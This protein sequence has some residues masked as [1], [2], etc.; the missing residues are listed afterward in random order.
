M[1]AKARYGEIGERV[2]GIQDTGAAVQNMRLAALE[3]GVK[4]CLLR[5]FDH[6]AMARQ[7]ELPRHVEPL[8]LIAMGYSQAEP[9]PKPC[10][11]LGDYL[12]LE[13]W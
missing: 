13:K 5:E 12:H 10:L 6:D 4:S 7:L 8:I 2:F 9:I 11:P 3:H 1:R